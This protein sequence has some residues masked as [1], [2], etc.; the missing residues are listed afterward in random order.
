MGCFAWDHGDTILTDVAILKAKAYALRGRSFQDGATIVAKKMKGCAKLSLE[1]VYFEHFVQLILGKNKY[2][3]IYKRQ[4]HFRIISHKVYLCNYNK[5]VSSALCKKRYYLSD[6]QTSLAFG[7][8]ILPE[9][10]TAWSCLLDILHSVEFNAP[11]PSQKITNATTTT[12]TTTTAT[13]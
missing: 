11:Y 6:M 2:H 8:F 9:V 12:T 4:E 1:D 7:H 3:S 5:A 10:R 13:T